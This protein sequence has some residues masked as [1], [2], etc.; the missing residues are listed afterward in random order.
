MKKMYT[1]IDRE[2]GVSKKKPFTQLIALGLS[3]ICCSVAI[4]N[5]ATETYSKI[6]DVLAPPPPKKTYQYF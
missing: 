2:Q 6:L 5:E 4:A 3:S 1:N